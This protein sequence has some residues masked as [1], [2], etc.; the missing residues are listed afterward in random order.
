MDGMLCFLLFCQL[1]LVWVSVSLI[2]KIRFS[3]TS[4]SCTTLPIPSECHNRAI[5]RLSM[6]YILSHLS[7]C[8][9]K[10]QGKML[11]S[12]GWEG[13]NACLFRGTACDL[14]E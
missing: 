3:A 14:V 8:W 13:F 9:R 1:R 2:G 7:T 6:I 12:L 10:V 4:D 5:L 11:V